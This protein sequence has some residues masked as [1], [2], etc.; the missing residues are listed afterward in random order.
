FLKIMGASVALAGAAGCIKYP[1]EAIVPY[2]QPPNDVVPGRPLYYATAMPFDGHAWPMIATAYE[3][4]PTKVDGNPDH[5]ASL[6]SSSAIGQA[7][8]LQLYDPERSQTVNYA[9]QTTTWSTF[10]VEIL[11][12]MNRFKGNKGKGLRFLTTP[13]SS[14][15]LAAQ[16]SEFFKTYP[17]AKWHVWEACSNH[18]ARQASIAAFGKAVNT[19]YRFD[20]A[21]RVVSL[22]SNFCVD[23]QGSLIYARQ[24]VN[25]RRLR[26][27]QENGK[28]LPVG[29][30]IIEAD[31]QHPEIVESGKATMNRLYVVET[32]Y[33][34][35]GAT[36]DHRMPL[37]PSEIEDFAKALAAG[38]GIGGVN[39]PADT[40]KYK[41]FLEAL[42]DDL[43]DN[44]GDSI[45]IA[46]RNQPAAVH[47]LA[48]A[49][50]QH[51]GNIGKTIF[52]TDPVDANP[53]D[54]VQSI[55][56]LAAD[57]AAGQVDTLII[58]DGNPAYDAPADLNFANLLN[59][60]CRLR[61]RF[62]LFYD[63]TSYY[64]HWHLPASHYLESW[65]DAR[66]YD[67]TVATI[68][69]LILPLYESKSAHELL[70]LLSGD[71]TSTGR[72]IVRGYWESQHNGKDFEDYWETTLCKGVVPESTFAPISVRFNSDALANVVTPKPANNDAMEVSLA[73]DPCIWDGTW[74]TN[75]WLQELPKAV[76]KLVWDNAALIS[77]A[78]AERLEVA[79]ESL[80]ELKYIDA[81]G[82]EQSMNVAVWV[83]PGHADDCITLYLGYGRKN[84]DAVGGVEPMETLGF[85]A[86][87]LRK[88]GNLSFSS[89]TAT[90]A[91][92]R[93]PL[94]STQLH[95]NPEGR[96]LVRFYSGPEFASGDA[97][98]PEQEGYVPGLDNS[99]EKVRLSLYPEFDYSHGHRWGMVIDDNACVGCNAC[100]IAC[101][102][103]NNS[104]I[105]GKDQVARYREMHWL[106]IDTWHFGDE[107]N[108][109][110][111]FEPVMCMMCE[112]A[113]CEVVCPVNATTHS[114]EGIN[115]MTY[116]RCVGTRYCSNN[117]PY[118]VRHF[119][120]L[121]YNDYYT[122]SLKMVRNPL[123]TV[124]E[125]GVMEKCTYCVQRLDLT[126]ID[127]KEATVARD[128]TKDPE[129]KKR[130]SD[131]I[132]DLM[133]GLQTA[134]QQAC[135]TE[136]LVFGDM[137]YVRPDNTP[138]RVTQLKNQ[139]PTFSLLTE[140]NTQPR[141][142][143]LNRF[144]NP[145]P[146]LEPTPIEYPTK[147]DL[148]G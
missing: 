98:Y 101:Q 68:Q 14:P 102:S 80:L 103:E 38:L 121:R 74:S 140:Y 87:P 6:G 55:R 113:P 83:M 77:P 10:Q 148:V 141:T 86:Y 15:T 47:V 114:A 146:A 107:S 16:Y 13:T 18:G 120:F 46:G 54:H 125:R 51:L 62:G 32:T 108:P 85:N 123:V 71:I 17:N 24:F 21:S 99:Q 142:S 8:I 89:V 76:T 119:N 129:E 69:P 91:R 23:E 26:R 40:T 111:V 52:Y 30:E 48:Q 61:I 9:A 124:R 139:Q 31:W 28:N 66:A 95:Q 36:A 12:E 45:I 131:R 70:A 112:H 2:V 115:E 67:G 90:S 59:T 56:E 5:P 136:A 96:D 110:T 19:I 49:I 116:N 143:Y 109:I 41:K 104:P 88:S 29:R 100:V 65:S 39:A 122:P 126:R 94:S 1:E 135:P 35:T 79:S 53:V 118:K 44:P 73:P 43:R 147:K 42:I 106:R 133:L 60:T 93:Y 37:K 72:E 117:C 22:D 92:G 75:G 64:C 27:P 57:M 3:G 138:S 105:V 137:N 82:K 130:Q 127:V 34:P 25:R 50:N 33:T 81:D 7:S 132:A 4:R 128:T 20:K 63:E 145:N 78:T 11:K 58:L 144:R 134:C 84:V 97:E